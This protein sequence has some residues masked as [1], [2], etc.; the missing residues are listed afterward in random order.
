MKRF[1]AESVQEAI[2]NAAIY[3]GCPKEDI[4]YEI[5]IES[6]KGFLGIGRKDAV[7]VARKREK[8]NYPEFKEVFKPQQEEYTVDKSYYAQ[9]DTCTQIEKN[10]FQERLTSSQLCDEISQEVDKLFALLPYNI[11]SVKVRMEAE[12]IVSIEFSGEDC[13]L[14]IGEKGYRYSSIYH[15]L[16]IWLKKEYGMGLRLEIADFLKNKE[17]RIEEYLEENYD[18]IISRTFFQSRTFDP[19]TA[20]I[21]LRRFREAMPDKYIIIKQ[22]SEVESVISINEFRTK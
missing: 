14:L 5:A 16:A 21:A 17:K 15:L 10:F 2:S 18:Q 20:N 8:E 11:D 19:L 12:G 4:E 3:F 1:S 6:S 22:I 7:I 13:G 9:K